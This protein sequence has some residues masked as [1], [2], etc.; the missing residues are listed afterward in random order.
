MVVRGPEKKMCKRD[1]KVANGS[2][3]L[4]SGSQILERCPSYK[5]QARA[6]DRYLRKPVR[7]G[8]GGRGEDRV[9]LGFLG[10]VVEKRSAGRQLFSAYL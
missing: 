8:S 10:G 4:K 9:N 3:E 7:D 2:T 5:K 6:P 1:K